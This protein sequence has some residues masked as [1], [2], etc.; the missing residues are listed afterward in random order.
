MVHAGQAA[1]T[2]VRVL[3]TSMNP[4]T[5]LTEVLCKA[6]GADEGKDKHD[7]R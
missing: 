4:P 1:E 5:L 2:S 3:Q 6:P 7:N